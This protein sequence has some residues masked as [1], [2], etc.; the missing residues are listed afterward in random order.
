MNS[1]DEEDELNSDEYEGAE[2][3]SDDDSSIPESLDEDLNETFELIPDGKY[4]IAYTFIFKEFRNSLF[5]HQ[6]IHRMSPTTYFRYPTEQLEYYL[7]F[8]SF[9]WTYFYAPEPARIR[10]V[11]VI[12]NLPHDQPNTNAQPGQIEP[13]YIVIDKSFWIRVLQRTW[14][15]KYAEKKRLE[16]AKGTIRNQRYFEIHGRYLAPSGYINPQPLF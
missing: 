5:E 8:Y 12:H 11:Q 1:S 7:E 6:I 9:Y 16:R 14:K 2:M 10:I 15:R 4:S 13:E 3:D